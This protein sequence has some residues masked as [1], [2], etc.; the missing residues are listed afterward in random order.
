MV[1]PRSRRGIGSPHYLKLQIE[2]IRRTM[3]VK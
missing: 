1:Y 2:F 3:G